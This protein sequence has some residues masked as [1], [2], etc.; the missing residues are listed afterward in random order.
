M[1]KSETKAQ[2]KETNRFYDWCIKKGIDMTNTNEVCNA[3]AKIEAKLPPKEKSI[4]KLLN[5]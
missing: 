2:H 3:F 4:Y 1:K 5:A